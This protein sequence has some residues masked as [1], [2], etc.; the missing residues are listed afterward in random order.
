MILS[1]HQPNYLPYIGFFHKAARSD[2]F[3]LWDSVQYVKRGTF[4]WMNRNRIKTKKGWMWLTVP[5]LTK[6]KFHQK[7]TD[8]LINKE[9]PWQRKH[10]RSIRMNYA[11]APHFDDYAG[12]FEDIY[13][14][15]WEKLADLNEAIILYLF[16]KFGVDAKIVRLSEFRLNSRGSELIIDVCRQLKADVFISGMHGRDYLDEGLF[17]DNG[18][19]LEYQ[20]FEH[21]VYSQLHGKFKPDLSAIDLLFNEGSESER[22]IKG[23]S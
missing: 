12:F 10:M 7:I 18:I 6:D 22:I 2:T 9:M 16:Q 8:V 14:R 4:G 11:Q 15:E 20:E 13:S 19:R 1:A 23:G 21:P 5:V 3:V 17:K